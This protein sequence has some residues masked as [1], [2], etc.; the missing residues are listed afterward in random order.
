MKRSRDGAPRRWCIPPVML[1]APGETIEG[2][3]LLEEVPDDLGVLLWR[4]VR[5]V[6]LWGE[7]PPDRR[8]RLF[9]ER[10]DRDQPTALTAAPVP[11]PISGPLD[12]IHRML[13]GAER[14]DERGLSTC[15]LEVAAW[16]RREGLVHSWIAFAQAAALASPQRAEA[17]L[18]TGIATSAAGQS[19]RAESWLRRSVDLARRERDRAAYATALGRSFKSLFEKSPAEPALP[20]PAPAAPPA[21]RSPRPS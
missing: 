16:A 5:D 8:A 9:V 1:R 3:D 6:S 15:C 18:Q 7:T 12:A 17:A 11:E 14:A 13:T 20:P 4:V 19:M 10:G 21:E 2:G